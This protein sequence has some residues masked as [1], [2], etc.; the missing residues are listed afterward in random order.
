MLSGMLRRAIGVGRLASGAAIGG[1]ALAVGS[2]GA[3]HVHGVMQPSSTSLD[4]VWR[5]PAM[6]PMAPIPGFERAVPGVTPFLP[7]TAADSLIPWAKPRQVM[8]VNDGHTI[9]ITAG[10]V[11]RQLAGRTLVM[12]GYNG[13]YPGPLLRVRQHAT[14][15]VRLAND[16]SWPTTVHWHGVRVD[17]RFDG[18]TTAMQVAVQPGGSFVYAVTFR[19]AGIYWY[20]PHQ[21]A[22]IQQD[23]GLAGN[24]LVDGTSAG[25]GSLAD[26]EEVLL[27]DDLLLDDQGI[28]P[29]GTEAPND[30][31]MGRFGN[32]LLVNGEPSPRLRA[33]AGEVVRYYLTNGA[34]ARTF[35]L[36]FGGARMKLNGSDVGRYEREEWV[37]SVVIAPAERYV[38]DVRF[39]RAGEVALVSR[40]QVVDA[41][42]GHLAGLPRSDGRPTSAALGAVD[43]ERAPRG[44]SRSTLRSVRPPLLSRCQ[45]HLACRGVATID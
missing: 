33:R 29:Y 11:R 24:I 17:N 26:R 10:R 19:D 4:S 28:L 21:R 25:G 1:I 30:A 44:W 23:L 2:A 8:P 38:V 43:H 31:L 40:V 6:P 35:N 41:L 36:S 42:R 14:I 12:Y 37:T 5:M 16:I 15:Y 32:V 13:Q 39:D 22:D 27:L 3:Q 18:V 45:S 7:S 34:S 9:T 20:H